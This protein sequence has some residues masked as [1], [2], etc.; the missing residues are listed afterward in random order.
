[1]SMSDKEAR[2]AAAPP[3]EDPFARTQF[4]I[5][6]IEH[7]AWWRPDWG[8]YTRVLA[9]AGRYDEAEAERVLDRANTVGVNECRV[10]VACV[11]PRA[12]EDRW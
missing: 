12:T 8:G 4:L 2:P 11:E 5:W 9:E 1:M 10:P 3:W 7:D 6:S